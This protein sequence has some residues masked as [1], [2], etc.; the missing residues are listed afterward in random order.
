MDEQKSNKPSAA[1]FYKTRGDW[2][3]LLSTSSNISHAEFRVAYFIARRMNGEDQCSWWEVK[4]IAKEVGC[5]TNTVSDATVK[6]ENLGL[7]L[8]IRPKRGV[9]RYFLRMPYHLQTH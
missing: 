8:V 7:L 6:L 2:L 9:N 4:E 3:D 5:S 1:A